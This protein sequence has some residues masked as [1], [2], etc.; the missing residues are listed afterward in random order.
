MREVVERR[1]MHHEM[2]RLKVNLVP[3]AAN[4]NP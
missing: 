1:Q 2:S 3:A 4:A